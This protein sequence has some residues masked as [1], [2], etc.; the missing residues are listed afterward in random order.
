VSSDPE[1]L[2]TEKKY[3]AIVELAPELGPTLDGEMF[4]LAGASRR[5]NMVLTN[6][7]IF[8]V[9]SDST[10]AYDRGRK[11][12]HYQNGDSLL[13]YVEKMTLVRMV[14]EQAMEDEQLR[15][16]LLLRA[17][18]MDGLDLAVFHK[19]IDGALDFGEF[20]EYVPPWEFVRDIDNVVASIEELIEEGFASD[21]VELSEYALSAVEGLMDY[22]VD[23]SMGN[24]IYDLEKIHH[25]ACKRAKPDPEALAKRL[26]EWELSGEYDTF[27]SALDTYAEVLGEKGISAYRRLAEEEWANVPALGPD[28]EKAPRYY[29]RRARLTHIME[30]LARGSGNV[31]DLVAIESRDLTSPYSYLRI[32][33]IYEE[34]GDDDKALEWA[35]EG[36]WVFPDDRHSGLS[37][38]VAERYHARGRHR[39]AMELAWSR[40]AESPD[41]RRYQWLKDHA[42]R[43]GDWAA[44]RE[45]A[46]LRVREDLDHM[47][48]ESQGWYLSRPLDHSVLVRI[49]LWEG[50]VE[51]AWREAKEGGCSDELWIELAELREEYAPEESLVIYF[52]RVEPLIQ[53]TNNRAYKAAYALLLKSR[54]LMTRLGREQESAE[55]LEIIRLEYKRKR[56]FMKLLEG[57]E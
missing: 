51:T 43:A 12:E 26:F 45:K 16:R 30:A 36:L 15:E 40:F 29:G 5:H 42:D 1:R 54:E 48:Q 9:L 14:M 10:A 6:L 55:Y 8:E 25:K 31:E 21:V 56:N 19:V 53:E 17:A 44:W 11:F 22:D 7:V 41:I 2:L 47:K 52:S 49:Y 18:R 28:P 39:E 23:G 57:L 32:A 33:R 34:A 13:I 46:L 24:V 35:E 20:P 3:L 50:E 38:F 27:S 37:D 4:A